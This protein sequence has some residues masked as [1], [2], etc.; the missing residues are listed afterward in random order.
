MVAK[1]PSPVLDTIDLL[2][3]TLDERVHYKKFYNQIRDAYIEQNELYINSLGCPSKVSPLNIRTYTKNDKECEQRKNSLIGLYSPSL[4]K[5]PY[6]ALET[7]RHKNGLVSCPMCGEPG[8]PRTLDHLLPKT[9]YPE[10]S[11]NLYNLVPCCDWCQGNKLIDYKNKAGTRSFL[12]PY[13]D[14]LDK[15]LFQLIFSGSYTAPV[16][17]VEIISGIPAD[18]KTIV[19]THL[20][21]VGFL[22]RY[23]DIFSTSYRSILRMAKEAREPGNMSLDKSLNHALKLSLD[24]GVNSWDAVLYRSILSDKR[25]INDLKNK[26]LPDF[27]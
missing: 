21:G 13:F 15:P 16:I 27:L 22:D 19:E 24:K 6:D 3:K 12:H 18:L 14:D 26:P 4:D 1:L 7:L 10:L 23:K 20:E 2:Q 9:I 8:R 17:E 5:L 11:I 25:I